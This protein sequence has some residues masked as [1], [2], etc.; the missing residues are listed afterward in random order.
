MA[1]ILL[2]RDL[3]T[4]GVKTCAPDSLIVDITRLLL[5]HDLEAVIVLDSEGHAAGMVSQN[6]LVRAYGREDRH[7]LTAEEVMCEDIPQ[8]P[9]DI[10]ITTAAQI[11]Q[12]QG[13]RVLFLMH[14]AEGISYPAATLSF[15]HL[16]RHLAARADAELSDLGGKAERQSPIETFIRRRDAAHQ[17]ASSRDRE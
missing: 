16:L 15:K 12:D 5:D 13:V 10:P 7:L 11:M 6:E 14:H 1:D 2:V 8:I 17:Q 4:V 9:P 3:M